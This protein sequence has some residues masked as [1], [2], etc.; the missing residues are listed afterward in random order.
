MPLD[1]NYARCGIATARV[2][3]PVE[4]AN[5]GSCILSV[6]GGL[7]PGLGCPHEGSALY[8]ECGRWQPPRPRAARRG[9]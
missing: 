4:C 6:R 9:G 5:L 1:D 8:E 2:E 7:K 3:T